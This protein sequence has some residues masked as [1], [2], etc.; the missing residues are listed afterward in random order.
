[1]NIMHASQGL[2]KETPIPKR[3]GQKN[4]RLLL[5]VR[6]EIAGWTICWGRGRGVRKA[7]SIVTIDPHEAACTMIIIDLETVRTIAGAYPP[8]PLYQ[9]N[10]H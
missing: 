8:K 10:H 9:G 5:K 1:M 2:Y 7:T 6:H 3:G 4:Q